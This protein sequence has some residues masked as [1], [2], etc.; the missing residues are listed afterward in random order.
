MALAKDGVVYPTLKLRSMGKRKSCNDN[1]YLFKIAESFG[2][3]KDA[4]LDVASFP[5]AK[6]AKA[7]ADITSGGSI[8]ERSAKFLDTCEDAG[9]LDEADEIFTLS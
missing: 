1:N 4:I 5:L 7:T 8:K 3:R 9:I 6:L 2:L